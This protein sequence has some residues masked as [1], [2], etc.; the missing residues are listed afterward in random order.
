KLLL[1]HNDLATLE[2][3][4]LESPNS[5][6]LAP[7]DIKSLTASLTKQD[8][9]TNA[10]DAASTDSAATPD[11]AMRKQSDRLHLAL[12]APNREVICHVHPSR[13]QWSASADSACIAGRGCAK[14]D[15]F[16]SRSAAIAMHRCSN[17]PAV[18]RTLRRRKASTSCWRPK[19]LKP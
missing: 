5:L 8:A 9:G 13:S 15:S 4:A 12:L 18:R 19:A 1:L 16:S 6:K 7:A 3:P 14:P 17:A 10:A 11:D 2:P